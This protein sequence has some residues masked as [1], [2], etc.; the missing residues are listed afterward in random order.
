M[1]STNHLEPIYGLHLSEVLT[2]PL[3]TKGKEENKD[4]AKVSHMIPLG[5]SPISFTP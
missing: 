1:L 2:D 3:G 4:K 5:E